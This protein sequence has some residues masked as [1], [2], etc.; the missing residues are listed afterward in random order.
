VTDEA[1]RSADVRLVERAGEVHVAVR[2]TDAGIT[3]SLRGNLSELVSRLDSAQHPGRC[4]ASGSGV[5]AW[6][7]R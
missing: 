6:R 2:A 3:E 1:A 5:D 7:G 4:L